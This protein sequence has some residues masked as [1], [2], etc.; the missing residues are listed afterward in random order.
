V[1]DTY[2]IDPEKLP[3]AIADLE[4]A[5]AAASALRNR[6][7][8]L[9]ANKP[10]NGSDEVSM[11]AAEQLNRLASDPMIDSLSSTQEALLAALGKTIEQ[12]KEMLAEYLDLEE[13]NQIPDYDLPGTDMPQSS[14]WAVSENR[15]P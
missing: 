12:F 14:S 13:V 5:Y 1:S 11:N 4:E 10:G 3:Q 2:E 15:S 8:D 7:L 6:V 9:S